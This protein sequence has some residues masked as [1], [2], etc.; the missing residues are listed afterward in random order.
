MTL[1]SEQPVPA[2]KPITVV[3][4]GKTT[5]LAMRDVLAGLEDFAALVSL[6]ADPCPYQILPSAPLQT[7]IPA[8]R[9]GHPKP[10]LYA[11]PGRKT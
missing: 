2:D 8:T 1:S 11:I 9:P 7:A 3:R 10:P 5:E 4:G 6:Q